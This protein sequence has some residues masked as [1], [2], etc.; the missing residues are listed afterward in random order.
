MKSL[1]A[2]SERMMHS[3]LDEVLL[4]REEDL[5]ADSGVCALCEGRQVALFWLPQQLPALYAIGN[6]DPLG[7]AN[8]LARGI[9]GDVDGEPV[10]ASPLYKQHYSLRDGRCLED[11][12]VRVPVYPVT[13]RDGHV[14][15][16]L[17]TV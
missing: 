11:A 15:C 12:A 13:L 8:V 1:S 10:V 9:V 5:V 6:H 17:P 4:C 14:Y 7:G 3:R 16:V 2:D